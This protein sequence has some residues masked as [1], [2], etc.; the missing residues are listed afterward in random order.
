MI[1]EIERDEAEYNARDVLGMCR[2]Y[3]HLLEELERTDTIN[4]YEY[5]E[6]MADLA[7][8]MTRVGMP[9]NSERRAEIGA[10]LRTLRDQAIE[11]L[12]PYT[13]GEYRDSFLDWV[14]AF[15]A[16][17]AR[18][19][20]PTAGATRVGAVRAAAEYGAARADLAAWKAYRKE[21]VVDG[22]ADA[23]SIDS[24]RTPVEQNVLVDT[25]TKIAA[26]V[27][28]VKEKKLALG[29]AQYVPDEE[30][31]LAHT[32]ETA[33]AVRHAIRRA[34]AILAVEKRGV[35]FG[36]KVQ[37]CAILRAAGVPL[38]KKT[39]KT[40]LPKIDKEVL[41]GLARHPAAKALLSYILTEKTIN[42]YIEGEKRA[43]K[44]GGK[45]RPVMVTEDGYIHPQWTIHKI[46]GRWG[47]S[48]NCFDGSTEIFARGEHFYGW[49]PLSRF[50]REWNE[51]KRALVGQFVPET[52]AVEMVEPTNPFRRMYAGSMVALRHSLLDLF[53]TEDH[54]L[55]MCRDF[56]KDRVRSREAIRLFYDVSV[57]DP[58]SISARTM[59]HIVTPDQVTMRQC[60]T[61]GFVGFRVDGNGDGWLPQLIPGNDV[62]ATNVEWAGPVY[63]LSVPSSYII[64][65]RNSKVCVVG[66]CQNWS[67]RAGGGAENLRSMIEAPEGYTLIGAD[68]KQIEARL[69]GAML[70]CRYMIDTFRSGGDIHSAMAAIGFPD[71]WPRLAAIFKDHKAAGK[72]TCPDCNTRNQMRDVTK[73]LEYGAFYGGKE[74]TLFESIVKDF[75]DS[76]LGQVR[77]FLRRFNQMLPE[78]LAWREQ[79]LEEAIRDGEIR[80]PI[81][82]RRQVF[83][84]GRVDPNVA[85]NYTAQSGA[86]DIWC[87]GAEKFM[88]LWDQAEFDARLINNSHDSV[89]ILVREELAAQVEQDVYACWNME[90]NGVPFE[91]ES[92]IAKQWSET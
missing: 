29:A 43:G 11:A 44:N 50:V 49:V 15:F 87:I 10:R 74:Q 37:Q 92:K 24:S 79:A 80:S 4:V 34:Q 65:R 25:D 14:A 51:G 64:V 36:A 32:V 58:I 41:E 71:V 84:L 3:P 63:C 68:Q 35:N 69:I 40:G 85:Y 26:L 81:L 73:R 5:D 52:G 72:C 53:V 38:H 66:Q 20:E 45:S 78:V 90:W 28:E 54:R 2:A 31:G 19:G 13:E 48:P 57:T 8:Q 16:V 21:V 39:E 77:E 30:D 12:R 75:P 22:L 18:K 67:K 59:L 42:V 6:L 17:K 56:A 33:Y 89:L 88:Q 82:G 91:M 23:V 27:E 47:S 46:T 61:H 76:T 62:E 7:L 83:P 9:V 60:D 1:S 86:A 55:F 70:Q